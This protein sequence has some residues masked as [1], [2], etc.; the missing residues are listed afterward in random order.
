MLLRLSAIL[1]KIHFEPQSSESR[2]A[3]VR[4]VTSAARCALSRHLSR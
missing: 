4:L 2:H 1:N 3:E